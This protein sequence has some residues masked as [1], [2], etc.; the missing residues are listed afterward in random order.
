MTGAGASPTGSLWTTRTRVQGLCVIDIAPT[1]D[2]YAATD[3]AY[4]SAYYHWFHLIQ[5]TPL[6]ETMILG[7]PLAV[8]AYQAGRLGRHRHHL[9]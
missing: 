8:F 1:L 6:P 2:M 4:A 9:H 7:A 3:F 5:P